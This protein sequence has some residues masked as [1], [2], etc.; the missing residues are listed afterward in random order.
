MEVFIGL[1]KT[2]KRDTYTKWIQEDEHV[3]SRNFR[4]C[5][6]VGGSEFYCWDANS[7]ES[8]IDYNEG[9]CSFV[10]DLS[11]GWISDREELGV[12][13]SILSMRISRGKLPLE[14]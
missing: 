13:G 3:L 5:M 2:R 11:L 14:S 9:V 8:T 1:C 7:T 4:N 6:G 12:C 10:V